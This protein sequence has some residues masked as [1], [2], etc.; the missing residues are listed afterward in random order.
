MRGI[1]ILRLRYHEGKETKEFFVALDS[2]DVVD[3]LRLLR[4]AQV[5][6]STLKRLLA[7][8]AIPQV[9][10]PHRES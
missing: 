5:K 4:R 6:E 2:E 3:L 9:E 7:E 1:H 10:I 8:C